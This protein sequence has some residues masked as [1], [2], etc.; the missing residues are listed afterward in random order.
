MPRKAAPTMILLLEI[1]GSASFR[2]RKS[3]T[4]GGPLYM[5]P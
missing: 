3:N 5:S 1:I 2:I 4:E